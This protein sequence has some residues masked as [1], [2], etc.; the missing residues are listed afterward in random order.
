M[1]LAAQ[2]AEIDKKNYAQKTTKYI[3]IGVIGLI[4][5]GGIIYYFRK[6]AK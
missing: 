6:K 3:V 1:R 2:Q 5:I 4:V